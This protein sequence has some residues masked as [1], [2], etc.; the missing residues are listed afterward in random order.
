MGSTIEIN[1]RVLA[2][3]WVLNL[4]GQIL[5]LPVALITIP[6]VIRGLGTERFGL[7]S[8]AWVLLGYIGLFDMGLG[9]AT[10]KFVAECLGRDET[11]RLP[12][13]VWTSVGSQVIFGL[14]GAF[15]AAIAT[16]VLVDR[17]LKISPALAGEAKAS[18]IILAASLPIVLAG[19]GF[20]GALEA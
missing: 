10:T 13:L 5:P 8:I 4:V 7:L 6:Y 3:N 19:N 12:G 9:R 20:R 17:F 11:H 14:V 15:L 16:P 2:R 1:G 18:F